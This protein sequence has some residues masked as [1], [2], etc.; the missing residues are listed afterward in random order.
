MAAN[1]NDFNIYGLFQ[2][3]ATALTPLVSLIW[4]D[5]HRDY[6]GSRRVHGED[7]NSSPG[8]KIYNAIADM[9]LSRLVS[10]PLQRPQG[11]NNCLSF[12]PFT[13]FFW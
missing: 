13:R 3:T 8:T 9:A 7:S 11:W 6:V 1:W 4:N 12:T 2:P 5:S 10:R